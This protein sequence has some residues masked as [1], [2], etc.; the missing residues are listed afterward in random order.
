MK[1][2]FSIARRVAAIAALFTVTAV[3]SS[4]ALAAV[5]KYDMNIEDTK[6]TLVEKQQFHTFAF[7]GQVPGPLFYVDEGD[8]IEVNV[9][10]VTALPHSIHWH[11]MLQKGTWKMDGIAGTT[12]DAIKPGE[13]FV[14][15]FTAEPS[16][17]MWYHCHVNVNEHVVLRGMWGPF[18]VRPKK[19]TALEKTVTKEFIMML[20]DWDSKWADKPGF[21]GIPG[22]KFDYFTING[23]SFPDN[24]PL[25]V[26]KGDVVRMRLIGAGDLVH[27]IHLHGHV[28]TVAFK[29]GFPLPAP[30]K[31]DTIAVAPGERYDVIFTADNPGLWMIHDHVDSHVMNGDRPMGGIMSVLEYNEIKP[32][33]FYEWKNKK[34]EPNFYYEESLKKGPGIYT[35]DGFKGQA[36]Q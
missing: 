21:G 2:S 35:N 27:S 8:Q 5:R 22:D 3:M 13:S 20:S 1:L 23:K 15:K 16:G 7:S 14:Y 6:I 19:P 36:V 17:T 28:M 10:N 9:N 32:D 24:Q 33:G 4:E 34:F 25:R 12:Q 18:I 29:D 11:G 30:Y 26:N 31:A